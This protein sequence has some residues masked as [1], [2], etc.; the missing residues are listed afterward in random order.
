[1]E[2]QLNPVEKASDTSRYLISFNHC[3]TYRSQ[4]RA[5]RADFGSAPHDSR[6]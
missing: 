5:M 1:M 4:S 2:S 3:V 6:A